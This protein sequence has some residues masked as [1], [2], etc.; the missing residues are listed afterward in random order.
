MPV[1]EKPQEI[2]EGAGLG[3]QAEFPKWLFMAW[4][5]GLT[6][7]VGGSIAMLIQRRGLRISGFEGPSR[8]PDQLEFTEILGKLW[9]MGGL[10]SS[11]GLEAS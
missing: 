2:G 1:P 5:R 11:Q 10:G 4:K 7:A 3:V 9:R 6:E 8:R